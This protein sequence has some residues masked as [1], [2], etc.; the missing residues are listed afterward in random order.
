MDTVVEGFA[1]PQG[2]RCSGRQRLPERAGESQMSPSME[3]RERMIEFREFA[4][5]YPLRRDRK[6]ARRSPVSLLSPPR[7]ALSNQRSTSNDTRP[8][9]LSGW[10]A[11]PLHHRLQSVDEWWRRTLPTD[12]RCIHKP[13]TLREA[14]RLLDEIVRSHLA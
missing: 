2:W 9:L 7:M 14:V 5:G 1:T 8:L 6:L 3:A 13:R 10:Q 4:P 12:K 11:S